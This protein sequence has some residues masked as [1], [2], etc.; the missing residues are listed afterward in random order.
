[1]PIPLKCLFWNV[2]GNYGNIS[3]FLN[4]KPQLKP[5]LLFI[6]EYGAAAAQGIQ[7]YLL[8]TPSKEQ[9]LFLSFR[10]KKSNDGSNSL[11]VYR[12]ETRTDIQ[13]NHFQLNPTGHADFAGQGGFRVIHFSYKDQFLFFVVHLPSLFDRDRETALAYAIELN[14]VIK[15]IEEDFFDEK[16]RAEGKR[17]TVVVGDFN[18]NPYESVM[19]NPLAFN[20]P[21]ARQS[22]EKNE[23]TGMRTLSKDFD[24]PAF[25]NPMWYLMGIANRYPQAIQ[26]TYN[27]SA[28]KNSEHRFKDDLM[29]RKHNFLDQILLR[30]DMIDYIARAIKVHPTDLSDHYPITFTLTI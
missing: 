8:V 27:A 1:M 18:V 26:G 9:S 30:T 23:Y 19:L 20:A 10:G 16:R 4:Q 17:Y 15:R 29:R 12:L 14:Q 25:Y 5:D 22:F 2:K 7:D 3:V 13:D 11:A 24:Y 28:S 6:A 21:Y